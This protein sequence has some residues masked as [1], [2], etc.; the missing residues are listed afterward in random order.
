MALCIS[1]IDEEE[2][3]AFNSH[4]SVLIKSNKNW[5]FSEQIFFNFLSTTFWH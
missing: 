1:K 3:C 4:A 2:Q 5:I